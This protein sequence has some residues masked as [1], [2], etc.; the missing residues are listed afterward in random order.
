MSE[1][2]FKLRA[3]ALYVQPGVEPKREGVVSALQ[4]RQMQRAVRTAQVEGRI[5]PSDARDEMATLAAIRRA[6]DS[7]PRQVSVH[8]AD[9]DEEIHVRPPST[10]EGRGRRRAERK[11]RKAARPAKR[12]K[13]R[14]RR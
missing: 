8:L 13:S 1:A 9:E 12:S 10:A 5:T 6:I 11:A 4:A 2:G 3:R 7:G 14:K